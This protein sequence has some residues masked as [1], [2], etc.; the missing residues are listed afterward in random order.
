MSPLN[1]AATP[2]L[3]AV[4]S[5]PTLPDEAL[6]STLD[7]LFEPSKELHALALP[8]LRTISF[9]SYE[10]LINTLRDELLAIASAVIEG[11]EEVVKP[12]HD[13]LGSHPRLGEPKVGTLSAL[14][15]ME[16]SHLAG[17][18]G[19]AAQ[20]GESEEEEKKKKQEE[21]VEKLRALNKEYEAKFPGLRYVVFVNGRPRP[22]IFED[23]RRRIDRGDLR[24]EEREGI[25]VSFF[26]AALSYTRPRGSYLVLAETWNRR[27]KQ[28][29]IWGWLRMLTRCGITGHVR[30]RA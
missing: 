7:L 12:L 28:Q 16:Q 25:M 26:L 15:K 27:G 9:N 22:V 14:S 20:G 19:G 23:M 3:P 17:G 24:A 2:F 30:H 13:I 4:T 10:D 1:P 18:G 21:E 29:W 11:N 5:L 6:K 8:T